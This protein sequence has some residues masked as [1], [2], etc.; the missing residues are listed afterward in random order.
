[1][2]IQPVI[3]NIVCDREEI[4]LKQAEN[5]SNQ[6][7]NKDFNVNSAEETGQGEADKISTEQ[8]LQ[9]A[10]E[11]A[12][13]YLSK[14]Q[15]TQADFINYKRAV[16]RNVQNLP[17]KPRGS[18]SGPVAVM[19][20]L[21]RAIESVPEDVD[22]HPWAEGIR[23]IVRKLLSVLESRGLERIESIGEHFDPNIHESVALANGKE[24]VVVQEIKAG[25][26]L[27]DRV[28]R[29]S[30]VIVGNGDQKA[31]QDRQKADI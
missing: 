28:L 31:S 23:H 27:Y 3:S 14:W 12:Q 4:D 30:S 17:S 8:K 15:R 29:P 1:M 2:I 19:D 21:D 25:Y 20:D 24:D 9:Q 26:R 6:E 22:N 18:N 10:E 7:T 13:D 11:K 16:S 5:T